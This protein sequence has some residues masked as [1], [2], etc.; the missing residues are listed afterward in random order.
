M[1]TLCI[2]AL[3]IQD[4]TFCND[5]CMPFSPLTFQFY[6]YKYYVYYLALKPKP[7]KNLQLLSPLDKGHMGHIVLKCSRDLFI[8]VIMYSLPSVTETELC[9]WT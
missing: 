7:L 1:L 9:L 4:D 6:Y 5:K 2:D 8:E 3:S